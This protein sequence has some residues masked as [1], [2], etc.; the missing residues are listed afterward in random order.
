V[1]RRLHSL[2]PR[3]RKLVAVL[4]LLVVV[5]VPL[6]GLLRKQG[7][8]MEE[9][10]MLVFA[11]QFLHGMVPNRDFLHL[12]GPG[13]VWVLAGVFKVFGT[14]LLAERLVGLAQL[15]GIIFGVFVLVLRPWGRTLAV[16]GGTITALIILPP[17]GLTALAWNGAVAFGL[18]GIAAG[19]GAT[20]ARTSRGANN[21][22]LASG[23]LFGLAILYRPDLVLA[24]VLVA[25]FLLRRL[26]RAQR[27][28]L[29]IAAGAVLSLFLVQIAMAGFHNSVQGMIIDPIFNLRGGR[30]LPIPLRTSEFDAFLQGAGEHG[31]LKWAIPRIP[32]PAQLT[33]WFFLLV[34]GVAL[35]AVVAWWLHRRE[36][37]SLR[38]VTLVLVAAFSVGIL[39][40]ALQRPD[41]THVAWVSCVPFAFF[42]VILIEFW[43][44]RRPALRWRQLLA[45]GIVPVVAFLYLVIPNYTLRDYA[46]ASG[47]T[48][49]IHRNAY[50]IKNDGRNFYYGRRAVQVQLTEI[51][52]LADKISKPGQ[53]LFVG[54]GDLR[55]TPYSDA[56]IYY[57]LPQLTPATYYIEMDPGVANA[58]NSRL[59]K[60]V[61]SANIVILSRVWDKWVEPNDSRLYGPET[62]N[63]VLK[64]EFCTVK[65]D[66]LYVLLQRC[67]HGNA[68][69]P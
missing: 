10:F 46:D 30:R 26:T 3:Q 41:T 36:P 47:Q 4:A 60:D 69:V 23:A 61:A 6:W 27:G 18:L 5:A 29:A 56:F 42:P 66:P 48:F 52:H 44:A 15:L 24:V 21:L 8:P 2:T 1:L 19:I 40:Q 51:L 64:R 32:A 50:E 68:P 25:I 14:S 57:M 11:E 31:A 58:S 20:S 35:L 12:Y 33:V 53:R 13:G 34:F 49:G 65:N 39:P 16:V 37:T 63:N 67:A 62:P 55:Q 17:I 22:A 59:A 7:P 9:G 45:L 54:S 28:R 43:R 38:S